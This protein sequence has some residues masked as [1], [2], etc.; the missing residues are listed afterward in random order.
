MKP[1]PER[2]KRVK[3]EPE[4]GKRVKPEPERGKRVNLGSIQQRRQKRQA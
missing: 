2:G 4:I 1:E 3:P